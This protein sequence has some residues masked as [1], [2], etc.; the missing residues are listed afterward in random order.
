MSNV[1]ARIMR[2]MWGVQQT[3]PYLPLALQRTQVQS[4]QGVRFKAQMSLC[5]AWL[6]CNITNIMLQEFSAI[7]LHPV[8]LCYIG[9]WGTPTVTVSG[10][11]GMLAG[12][13]ASMIESIGDYYAA[14]RYVETCLLQTSHCTR[15]NVPLF[16]RRM[17][18]GRFLSTWINQIH[19]LQTNFSFWKFNIIIQDFQYLNHI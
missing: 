17:V 6:L 13:L 15:P 16:G 1:W 5:H 14:A 10:V 9:Q 7:W 2:A 11:F 12:V 4:V 19:K 18:E 8:T 3:L